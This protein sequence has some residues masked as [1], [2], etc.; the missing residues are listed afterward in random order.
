MSDATLRPFS[1]PLPAVPDSVIRYRV[2]ARDPRQHLFDVTCTLD[3]PHADGQRFELPVWVPG[4]YLVRE[5]ARHVVEVNAQCAGAPVDVTKEDKSTWRVA[6]CAGPLT[7]TATVYAHDL[8]VRT[9]YLDE[10]RGYFNGSSVFLCP[11]GRARA[12][13]EVTIGAPSAPCDWRV[14]TTLER[15]D[16]D[17]R[18]FGRY[19]AHSYDELI[20]HPVEMSAFSHVGFEAGGVPHEIAISGTHRADLDRLTAD[21]KRVCEWQL[22]L[23]GGDAP[24]SRYLF[25]VTAVGDGYGGL[26]HRSSTSLLCSR[27][28]LPTPGMQGVGDDYRSFLGLASHEYFHAWHVKRIKPAAFAPYDLSREA[29]TRQLWAFEGFTSYYDDLAL[30]RSGVID[31]SSYLELLGRTISSVLRTPG[32]RVQSLADSSFDAWI[33]FYR[34]DEDTPNAV[35]SYYAKGAV[36]ALALDLTLRMHGTSLDELMRELWGRYGRT[37]IGVPE[38]AI[39]ELASECARADLASFFARHVE[40]TDEPPLE[41]LLREFAVATGLRATEGARDRGGRPPSAE[42]PRASLGVKLA[43]GEAKVMYAFRDGAAARAGLA[44]GDVIVAAN[45]LKVSAESLEK[46]VARSTPGDTLILHAFRR[47]ELMRIEVELDA[48]VA[49]TCYLALEADPLAESLARRRAWLGA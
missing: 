42:A 39:E 3:D 29:Y 11:R 49:D 46:L 18:G 10:S 23:F 28:D 44:A 7:V 32:R 37:G 45:R 2:N 30:L 31:A 4:S 20:D 19:C 21:L 17:A 8:S 25:Q 6:P 12:T 34:P 16:V 33:K 15:V 26:E 13:F 35:V 41:Q 1:P 27:A 36:V 14:A 38:G 48:P 40:G 5:L 22:G 43:S 47:D 9:A 24:F